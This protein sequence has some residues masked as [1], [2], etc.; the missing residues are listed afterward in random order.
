MIRLLVA[1]D[2]PTMRQAL[3]ED[4]TSAGGMEVVA[5]LPTGEGVLCQVPEVCPDVVLMDVSV[6]GNRGAETVSAMRAA[7][8]DTPV[9]CLAD[10]L[11]RQMLETTLRSRVDGIAAR[12]G[13]FDELLEGI[14]VVASGGSYVSPRLLQDN[15]EA[16]PISASPDRHLLRHLSHRE[17]EII[18]MIAD[19][20]TAANIAHSLGISGSTVYFHR[21]NISGKTGLKQTADLTRFAVRTGLLKDR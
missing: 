14:G 4:I 18:A 21:N 16:L 10:R 13:A 9:L 7:N 2:H 1:D 11:D 17:R 8:M 15:L 5:D 3:V 19:G 12:F 20:R 6:P